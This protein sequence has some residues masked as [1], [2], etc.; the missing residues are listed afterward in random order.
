MES[1]I[2]QGSNNQRGSQAVTIVPVV[3][4]VVYN[5]TEQNIPEYQITSQIDVLNEDYRRLNAD[6]VNTRAVFNA[7]SADTEIEF[8]LATVDPS[9][10]PTSGITRTPTSNT[11]FTITN[12]NVKTSSTGGK[13]PWPKEQYLNIWVCNLSSGLL[14]YATL[15][16]TG[17]NKDGVVIGYRFF[18]R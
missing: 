15:P 16:G 13:D 8:C 14:G 1:E 6:S 17:G 3:V 4:H 12:D 11:Y 5:T 9:G 10:N 2:K 18:G 7:L